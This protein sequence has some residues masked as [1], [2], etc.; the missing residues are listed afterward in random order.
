[1]CSTHTLLAK[2]AGKQ[3]LLC[4]RTTFQLNVL[5]K[6]T[7]T[8]L[9]GSCSYGRGVLWA[10]TLIIDANGASRARGRITEVA[11]LALQSCVCI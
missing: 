6:L 11:V 1:M 4:N 3:T 8:R 10:C 2:I 9:P 7:I 5:I